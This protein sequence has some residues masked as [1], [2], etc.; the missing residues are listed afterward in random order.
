M[1][2][3]FIQLEADFPS[4]TFRAGER[5]L[6][7]PPHTIF[8]SKDDRNAELL[9]LHEVSHALLGHHDF[10]TDVGRLRMES[11]AWEKARELASYYGIAVDEELIQDE[12]DTYRNW[13]HIKSKCKK[14]GLTRFQTRDQVYHCPKCD[15]K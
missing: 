8:L 4:L 11:E 9:A 7:R 6:F 13:L 3:F 14:C 15:L 10:A 12:L 1:N 2:K 5:F